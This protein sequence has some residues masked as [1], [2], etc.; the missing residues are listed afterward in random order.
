MATVA[1][2]ICI[3]LAV[4]GFL[5]M[6]YVIWYLRKDQDTHDGPH[7]TIPT[8]AF[9]F[10]RPPRL[11]DPYTYE[12]EIPAAW[13]RQTPEQ[14][15]SP[16]RPVQPEDS[17]PKAAQNPETTREQLILVESNPVATDSNKSG[18]LLDPATLPDLSGANGTSLVPVETHWDSNPFQENLI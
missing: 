8:V 3:I 18:T 1:V 4:S 10:N 7:P 17:R 6:L 12:N 11:I 14:Q 16:V 2:V 15:T 5:G 9:S 13:P